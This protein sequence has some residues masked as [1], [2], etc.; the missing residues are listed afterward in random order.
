VNQKNHKRSTRF[1][2]SRRVAMT[3]MMPS[4]GSSE[5]SRQGHNCLLVLSYHLS[6]PFY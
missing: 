4:S 1:A 2:L 6:Y 5:S 3:M